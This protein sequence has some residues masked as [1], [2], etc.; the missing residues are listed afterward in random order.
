MSDIQKTEPS[1]KPT[2]GAGPTS[3][4]RPDLLKVLNKNPK[5][6]YRWL[7][8]EQL[9]QNGGMHHNG[10]RA[11]TG[12]A[13]AEEDIVKEHGLDGVKLVDGAVRKYEMILAFMPL[14]EWRELK[15]MKDEERRAPLTKA[16]SRHKELDHNEFKQER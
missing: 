9:R 8:F 11:L 2:G 10:W 4:R 1:K 6:R 3:L 12:L 7:N 16:R 5:Y 15:M 14:A 13:K